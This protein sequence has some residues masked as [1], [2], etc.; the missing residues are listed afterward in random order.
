MFL[1]VGSISRARGGHSACLIFFCH[2]YVVREVESDH[3]A[4]SHV[5]EFPV[6]PQRGLGRL[7]SAILLVFVCTWAGIMVVVTTKSHKAFPMVGANAYTALKHTLL[8]VK[9]YFLIRSLWLCG[10][11]QI[12]VQHPVPKWQSVL[13]VSNCRECFSRGVVFLYF[14]KGQH[15]LSEGHEPLLLDLMVNANQVGREK[16][17]LNS[18]NE[19]PGGTSID[20]LLAE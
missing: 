2:L 18:K 1:S 12:S 19:C 14:F 13:V 20:D 5:A 16:E 8:V 17:W 4:A 3:L 9:F 10:V 6:A 7:D 15:L 11:Q